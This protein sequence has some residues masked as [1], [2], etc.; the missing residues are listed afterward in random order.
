MSFQNTKKL[1]KS[2]RVKK[3]RK[4]VVTIAGVA[5][6]AVGVVLI[7]FPGPAFVVIPAGFAILAIEFDWA[8]R[9]VRKVRSPEFLKK[10]LYENSLTVV[11]FGLFLLSFGGQIIAGFQSYNNERGDYQEPPVRLCDYVFT[12]HCVEA[13]FENW[14]SEF[15]Q[16]GMLVILTIY[17]RQRGAPD[18]KKVNAPNH[19]HA[20]PSKNPR[21]PWPVRHGGWP[22]KIYTHSL[23]MA[24]FGLFLFSFFMHALG[25]TAEFNEEQLRLG[26]STV[27]TFEFITTSQFWFQSFQNWQ[28]EFLSVAVLLVFSIFLRQQGSP[29]SKPVAAPYSAHA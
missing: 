15:L 25:G 4:I 8:R 24:L 12:G 6:I 3:V 2:P 27:S 29:Q 20:G 10:L 21:A 14:E 13:V 1:L 19:H 17:F 23:S 28:S 7:F 16:M 9:W 5:V 22:L 26:H 18:S 11:L